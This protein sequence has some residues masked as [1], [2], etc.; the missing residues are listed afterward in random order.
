MRKN[1]LYALITVLIWA[2]MAS[3]VKKI[4][5]DI[6][7]LEALSISSYF[8]FVFLLIMKIKSI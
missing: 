3:V 6:P 2:T 5:F 4:L 8:S 1:Y 7:N